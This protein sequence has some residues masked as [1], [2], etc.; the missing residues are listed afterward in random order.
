MNLVNSIFLAYYI[1]I[2]HP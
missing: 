2:S 1:L